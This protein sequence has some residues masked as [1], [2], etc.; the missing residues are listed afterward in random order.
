MSSENERIP[1]GTPQFRIDSDSTIADALT[2]AAQMLLLA[3]QLRRAVAVAEVLETAA[4]DPQEAVRYAHHVAMAIKAEAARSRP[5]S[6]QLK[7]LLLCG[8]MAGVGALEQAATPDLVHLA[9]LALHTIYAGRAD[10][11]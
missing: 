10:Q 1:R 2:G 7:R 5:S 9:S 3:E 8:I 6:R 4:G 11:P